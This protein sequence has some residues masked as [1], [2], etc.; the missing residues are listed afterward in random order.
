MS[1]IEHPITFISHFRVKA[2]HADAFRGLWDSVAASLE[3]DKPATSAYL[4]Y[5]SADAQTLTIVHVFP[6]A[7]AMAAA[8]RGR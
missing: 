1:E 2:G 3:E 7:D 8:L 4:G 6:D 5:L